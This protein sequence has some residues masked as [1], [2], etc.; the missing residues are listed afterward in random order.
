MT[1]NDA[2]S[3]FEQV[4]VLLVEDNVL[5]ARSVLSTARKAKLAVDVHHVE[6]GQSALD[7]LTSHPVDLMLLDLNLPGLDGYDV[8]RIVRADDR[9]RSMPVVVLTTSEE[10]EDIARS[11]ALGANAFVTKPV[12]LDGWATVVGQ[13]ESFWFTLAKLPKP[14]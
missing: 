11:Y 7:Y 2:A 8:L 10:D 9:L 1:S 3:G 12:G 14:T 5:D 13:I 6:D 4:K